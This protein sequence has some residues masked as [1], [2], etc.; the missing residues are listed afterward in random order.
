MNTLL[1]G[2]LSW[3]SIY[4]TNLEDKTEIESEYACRIIRNV[5]CV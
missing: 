5:M 2:T 1:I 3:L 4:F